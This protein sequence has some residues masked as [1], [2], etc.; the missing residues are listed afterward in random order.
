MVETPAATK[1]SRSATPAPSRTPNPTSTPT[2]RVVVTTEVVTETVPVPHGSHSEDDA[3]A[4]QGTSSVVPGADGVLTRTFELVKNDGVEVS[5]TQVSESVTTAPV[6][7]I[8]RV[9]VRVPPAP[10]PETADAASG[11]D[12][13]YSGACVPIA[14]DVD[15]AGGKGNG[16]AYV[17]GP[18]TVIGSDIYDLDNNNNGV[19]CE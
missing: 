3:S 11:C 2:P 18:V 16:P 13:N 8:T 19:G 5:R 7:E 6:D 1:P 12:P 9:G 14:S 17:R 4:D 10:E 15:C